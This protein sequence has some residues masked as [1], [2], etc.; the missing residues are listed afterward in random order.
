MT[1]IS[2]IYIILLVLLCLSVCFRKNKALLYFNMSL[3]LVMGIL[4]DF[5]VGTDIHVYFEQYRFLHDYDDILDA[6]NTS[7]EPGFIAL[8]VL[9]KDFVKG[10]YLTFISLVFIPFFLGFMKFISYRKVSAPLALL[11][12]YMWGIYFNGYNAMRQM[13]AIGT[14]LFFIPLLYERKY[15]KF[16]VATVITA[17]LFHKTSVVM[18]LLIPF[19]YWATVK[20]KCLS[21]KWLYALVAMS[22]A[23][24]FVGKTFFQS[25]LMPLVMLY[26][27]HYTYYVMGNDAEEL[28]YTF[29]LGQSLAACLMIYLYKKKSMDFEML[30]F[31][32]G[33]SVYNIMGMFSTFG[34]RLAMYWTMFGVV[35]FPSILSHVNRRKIRELA[36][37]FVFIIYL[38]VRFFY[39]YHFN[40]IDEVNPYLFR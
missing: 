19:H 34:P 10:E 22:F 20:G 25:I 1:S 35:L 6:D 29:N 39:S 8:I 9:F 16:A 14:T 33:I 23:M 15:L 13:L 38:F 7:F 37:A 11:F 24:F 31:I 26:D 32:F 4:R 3:M 28:G 27:E 40:N 18:L 12:F 2:P 36:C 5:T 21:K 30:V 17:L